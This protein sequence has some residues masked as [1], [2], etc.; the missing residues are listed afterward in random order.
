MAVI[1]IIIQKLIFQAL[2][3]YINDE[4]IFILEGIMADKAQK[5]Q[6]A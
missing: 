1:F 2:K 6:L 5:E 3:Q 4:Q